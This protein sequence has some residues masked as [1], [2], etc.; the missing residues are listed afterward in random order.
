MDITADE[1]DVVRRVLRGEVPRSTVATD[2]SVRLKVIVAA[3]I[4][5]G[6]GVRDDDLI[7]PRGIYRDLM[8]EFV[9]NPG[10]PAE[11]WSEEERYDIV[12]SPGHW[13]YK[14]TCG[15]LVAAAHRYGLHQT[16][17][18]QGHG[19]T[20][21]GSP[22]FAQLFEEE[23]ALAEVCRAWYDEARQGI[24]ERHAEGKTTQ[25]LYAQNRKRM[26]AGLV[27][28][29]DDFRYVVNYPTRVSPHSL[30]DFA[31][32]LNRLIAKTFPDS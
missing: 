9:V 16:K 6:A 15:G 3:A 17:N 26:R 11:G 29:L 8:E 12:F 23:P 1:L 22:V 31:G 7:Y 32:E 30:K 2:Y 14:A 13:H 20:F 10:V 24:L 21:V 4:L 28:L 18:R 25:E 19:V 5:Q 27:R